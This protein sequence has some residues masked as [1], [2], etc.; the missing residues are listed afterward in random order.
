[1][2]LS[3]PANNII[4]LGSIFL[5]HFKKERAPTFTIWV[6]VKRNDPPIPHLLRNSE[7]LLEIWPFSSIFGVL[8]L[9]NYS[10]F[11]ALQN[12]RKRND[13]PIPNA[14]RFFKD[15]STSEW[16]ELWQIT[17]FLELYFITFSEFLKVCK[18]IYNLHT[19]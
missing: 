17:L 19:F 13:I 8:E 15:S 4:P 2:R 1:M 11:E 3:Y 14:F 10:V 12:G 9:I 16:T 6:G 7:S 5:L 18:H